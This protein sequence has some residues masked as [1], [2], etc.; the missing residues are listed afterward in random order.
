[1]VC[2]DANTHRARNVNSLDISTAEE[3]S[4]FKMGEGIRP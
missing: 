2:R 4:L 1:M 3:K